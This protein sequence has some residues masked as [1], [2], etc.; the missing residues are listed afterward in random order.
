MLITFSSRHCTFR[1]MEDRLMN[2]M[3]WV[4]AP[5]SGNDWICRGN[6]WVGLGNDW[7]GLGNDWVGLSH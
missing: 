2:T 6:D 4:G 1:M 3:M 5:Q 7:V